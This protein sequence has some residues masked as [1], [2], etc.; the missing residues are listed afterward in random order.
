M[1]HSD[2]T[3][4]FA[5]RPRTRPSTQVSRQR[6]RT[7]QTQVLLVLKTLVA[8]QRLQPTASLCCNT[9]IANHDT[10]R[11]K[12][13][14]YPINYKQH[15]RQLTLPIQLPYTGIVTKKPKHTAEWKT[16][17]WNRL[18]IAEPKTIKLQN[19][20]GTTWPSLVKAKN[21]SISIENWH[22]MSWGHPQPISS[23][24]WC[25]TLKNKHNLTHLKQLNLNS[26]QP[27]NKTRAFN[28]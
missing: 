9:G 14:N 1:Q 2:K 15:S 7:L 17:C 11:F 6:P 19:G 4:T 18:S 13:R 26:K 12:K 20:N 27:C 24:D 22:K 23:P 25:K 8:D 5:G 3:E 16:I 28:D 10:K 21:H